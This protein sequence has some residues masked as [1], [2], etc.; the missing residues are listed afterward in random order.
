MPS[1]DSQGRLKI[2]NAAT[3]SGGGGGGGTGTIAIASGSGVIV[4]SSAAY[5]NFEGTAVRSVVQSGSGVSVH[6]D[7]RP[8]VD[9]LT[10][11]GEGATSAD[12]NAWQMSFDPLSGSVNWCVGVI[13][14][15]NEWDVGEDEQR[16]WSTS[17]QY[18]AGGGATF[19]FSE[20]TPTVYSVD[21][22]ATFN[23]ATG[24]G[25]QSFRSKVMFTTV[26]HDDGL[27]T[28]DTNGF[29]TDGFSLTNTGPYQASGFPFTVGASGQPLNVYGAEG[30]G[31]H[32]IGYVTRSVSRTEVL[33]WWHHIYS[34]G[35]MTDIP[36]SSGNG[37]N[38]AWKVVGGTNPS[39]TTWTPFIGGDNLVKTG[40]KA[41]ATSSIPL[42][43]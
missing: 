7:H 21:S 11:F 22:G 25:D 31:I 26:R 17:N 8:L 29:F 6:I 43:W 23:T 39:G 9:F 20:T 2:V 33:R 38:G 41:H 36:D 40:S 35:T 4:T 15:R 34:S 16:I 28:I 18:L 13:Y 1:Y 30:W 27:I 12:I 10:G 32:A 3:G 14:T 37:L 42:Y 5:I 19:A 24:V